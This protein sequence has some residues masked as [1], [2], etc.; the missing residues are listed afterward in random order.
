MVI[1]LQWCLYH[2]DKKKGYSSSCCS[3]IRKW[4]KTDPHF[5]KCR[6]KCRVKRW[7]IAGK[8]S[9]SLRARRRNIAFPS[10]ATQL[11]HL[12]YSFT[13]FCHGLFSSLLRRRAQVNKLNL[14]NLADGNGR[15]NPGRLACAAL[16]MLHSFDQLAAY[17]G[18]RLVL[19]YGWWSWCMGC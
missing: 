10:P 4:L 11:L 15:Q 6:R 14:C 17:S 18:S 1:K 12:Y 8:C 2:C 19:L 9:K 5:E 3:E 7:I 16:P 13:V